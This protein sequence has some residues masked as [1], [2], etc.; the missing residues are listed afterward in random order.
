MRDDISTKVLLIE[1]MVFDYLELAKLLYNFFIFSYEA[2]NDKY[3][4]QI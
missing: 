1:M 4:N 3:L 2:I